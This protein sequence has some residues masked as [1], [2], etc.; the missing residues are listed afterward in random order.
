MEKKWIPDGTHYENGLILKILAW[1][2]LYLGQN[3]W[4]VETF[5]IYTEVQIWK[6]LQQRS[7]MQHDAHS[8]E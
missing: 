3:Y 5:H 7:H 8:G 6:G 1:V 2:M 4:I